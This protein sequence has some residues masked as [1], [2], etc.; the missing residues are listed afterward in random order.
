VTDVTASD[1][2]RLYAEATGSGLP[3]LF[4]HEFAADHRTWSRQVDAA[5]GWASGGWVGWHLEPG[6]PFVT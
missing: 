5:E 3:L 6:Q 4:I 2:V 1:G